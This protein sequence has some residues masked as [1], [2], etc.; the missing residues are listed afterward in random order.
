MLGRQR[1]GGRTVQLQTQE[2]RG[3]PCGRGVLH[4]VGASEGRRGEQ[5]RGRH[6]G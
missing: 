3:L 6:M 5:P 2:D 1:V 4:D